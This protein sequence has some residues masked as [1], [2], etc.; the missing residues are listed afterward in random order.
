MDRFEIR[1]GKYGQYFHD[2]KRGGPEGFSMSLDHVLDKL[3]RL[4]AY[5]ERLAA[6]NKRHQQRTES[7]VDYGSKVV[8]EPRNRVAQAIRMRHSDP[9]TSWLDVSEAAI[10]AYEGYPRDSPLLPVYKALGW[11]GGTIHQVVAEIKRLK[12]LE[13]D[14]IPTNKE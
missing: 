6:A 11:Q 10:L 12:A 1:T 13:V 3:N 7:E 9:H 5:T 2:T 14:E 4:E 8:T